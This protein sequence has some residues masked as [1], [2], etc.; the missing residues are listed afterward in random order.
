[1]MS[2]DLSRQTAD[3]AADAAPVRGRRGPRL[4]LLVCLCVVVCALV[5]ITVRGLSGN[6]VYYLTPT[7]IVA[8]HKAQVGERVRL[9]GYVV[10]G[11]VQRTQ[12]TLNFTVTDGTE[13]MHVSDT[14]SVPELFRPGQGVVLE[15]SLGTDGRFHADTILVRHDGEYRPPEPGEK[16][17][18]RADRTGS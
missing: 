15:G 16:P 3:A 11:S 5:F 9:G 2:L 18:S 10:P 4:R 14:G 8:D 1:M 17:L 12:S 6:F 13:S 7:D